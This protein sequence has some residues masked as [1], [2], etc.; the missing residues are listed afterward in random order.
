MITTVLFDM[1]GTLEDIFVDVASE[2]A[3]VENLN[4]MLLDWGL[5]P[6][7][8]YEELKQ[9]V[10]AGWARYAAFR[11]KTDI[12]RKPV[13]IWCDYVLS[14]FDFPRER[15]APH[16]EEIAHMWEVTHFHR[17]LRPRAAEMLEGLKALGLKLGIVSNTAALF[18]VFDSLKDYGIRNYFQ[19][20]TL[21][22]VTELR[23]P[24]PL[25]FD[26]ALHQLQSTAAES[27]YV[28]DT[29]SRDIIG[30]KR[31][32][33]AKA[34]QIG[35]QL[36]REKDAGICREYEP[37]YIVSDIYDVLPILKELTEK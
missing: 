17:A 25:I 6:G 10:D 5:D 35:S 13:V 22:S 15:L 2:R 9:R 30:S 18:Q 7:V 28:G 8:P 23:K 19:D 1:G 16:C 12:E 34:I 31:A 21:S 26:V 4:H 37:D 32:G 36:T 20:V 3:A 29:V 24:D 11:D 27:V 14:D 33:F